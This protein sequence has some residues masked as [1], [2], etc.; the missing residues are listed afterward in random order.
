[1]LYQFAN[2][3]ELHNWKHDLGRPFRVN[4]LSICADGS[5]LAAITSDN[6]I[7]IYNLPSRIRTNELKMDDKLT[8]INL[9]RDGKT[10]LVSMNEGRLLLLDA[11]TGT[12]IQRYKGLKQ[13][14]FVIR[15]QFGGAGQNFVIS[16]SE[17]ELNGG[18]LGL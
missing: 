14:E 1:M 9:S 10:V 6:Y 5:R 7:L 8:C 18:L 3:H 4:D 15:S 12:V 17:G 2:Q 16:G 11:E 13:S